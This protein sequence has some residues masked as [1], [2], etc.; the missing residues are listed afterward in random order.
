MLPNYALFSQ[1]TSF[2]DAHSIEATLS[3]CW[4]W[5]MS[6]KSKFNAAVQLEKLEENIPDIDK[7]DSFAVYPA[8]DCCMALSSLLQGSLNEHEHFAVTVAKLS[9]GS[10]EAFILASENSDMSSQEIKAHEL[11][12]YE[13]DTQQSLVEYCQTT[14]VDKESV[15][16]LK[17]AMLDEGVS[18]LG[19]QY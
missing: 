6:P 15:K 9:Q 8:L 14:K 2:G 16:Q 10:V 3:L 19:M 7:F 12:M 18:N 13:I 11:M 1:H 5:C 17:Q 4:E